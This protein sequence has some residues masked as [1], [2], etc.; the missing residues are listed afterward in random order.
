MSQAYY[1]CRLGLDNQH[2]QITLLDGPPR[3]IGSI[4]PESDSEVRLDV[5][6]YVAGIS[7]LSW[8]NK[9]GTHKA[10]FIPLDPYT[11]TC[12]EEFCSAFTE[13]FPDQIVKFNCGIDHKKYVSFRP[14]TFL[15]IFDYERSGFRILPSGTPNGLKKIALRK[16]PDPNLWI[17]GLGGHLTLRT[18]TIVSELFVRRYARLEATGLIFEKLGTENS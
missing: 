8:E 17:F 2:D 9:R 12:E 16:L 5:D 18:V 3:L 4:Y 15:D 13:P 10:N 14:K 7:K 1:R 11:L 6:P